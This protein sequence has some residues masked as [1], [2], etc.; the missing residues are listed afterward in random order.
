MDSMSFIPKHKAKKGRVCS[1]KLGWSDGHRVCEAR[2]SSRHSAHSRDARTE[3]GT[4][5]GQAGR[6]QG[7][8]EDERNTT[9]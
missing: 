4:R 3:A 6:G 1:Q 9:W 2:E 8:T 7:S 5:P